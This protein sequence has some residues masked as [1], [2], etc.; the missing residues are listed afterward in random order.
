MAKILGLALYQGAKKKEF[1]EEDLK[2]PDGLYHFL[3]ELYDSE[4]DITEDGIV[5]LKEYYGMEKVVDLLKEQD[6]GGVTVTK[7]ELVDWLNT[8]V[9]LETVNFISAANERQGVVDDVEQN[10]EK[11]KKLYKQLREVLLD[12]DL[13][14]LTGGGA[15]D[16]EY[17][18][19][20]ADLYSYV[21]NDF[22]DTKNAADNLKRRWDTHY[23]L[24]APLESY[25]ELF[26]KART[27]LK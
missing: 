5:F 8:I 16:D 13:F 18:I 19:I 20:I 3:G 21:V 25:I 1:Y 14:G 11:N 23:G 9:P 2:N 24:E 6:F 17:D 22:W 7:T 12:V 4:S 10:K 26:N 27:L 15:P